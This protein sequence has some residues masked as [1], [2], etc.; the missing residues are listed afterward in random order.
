ML[1]CA[2]GFAAAALFFYLFKIG[3][4]REYEPRRT[5]AGNCVIEYAGTNAIRRTC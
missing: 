5:Y 4:I 3:W 2:I 1:K